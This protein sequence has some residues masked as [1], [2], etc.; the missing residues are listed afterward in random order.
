MKERLPEGAQQ[1]DDPGQRPQC[2][3]ADGASMRAQES[4]T[5]NHHLDKVRRST[6]RNV[7]L[8]PLALALPLLA[9]AALAGKPPLD[10]AKKSLSVAVAKARTKPIS[11]TGIC[12]GPIVIRNDG[13]RL[14]GVG[15]AIINGEGQD[16]VTIE[17]A[18][19]VSLE[20]MEVRD[21]DNGVVGINGAHFSLTDVDVLSNDLTGIS[22]QNASSAVLTRVTTSDNG[23]HGLDVETGSAATIRGDFASSGNGVFGVN[24]NGS[25]LTL[26]GATAT[27][28]GNTIGMQVATGANAF[29]SDSATLLNVDNNGAVGLTMVSGGHMVSFGGDISASGNGVNGVSLNS[30]A[31]LDLDAAST[32]ECN[33]NGTGLF[34]Q[35]ESEVTVFNTPQFSGEPGFSTVSCKNNT[36]KGILVRNASNLRLSG[37]AKVISTGN[38]GAGLTADDGAGV[39]LVSSE[40]KG[41]SINPTDPADPPKDIE[42]SFGT[43]ADIRSST[44]GTFSCDETVLL[45][46]EN[47]IICN[48]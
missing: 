4:A 44:I 17:G 34:V 46:G 42:L 21:G 29:I 11:F 20:N 37:Q 32:L 26:S 14:I 28:S 6:M 40:I 22:L 38:S 41:N 25:A 24:V 18:H 15:T 31:G 1:K 7:S 47:D 13:V 43:R 27:V 10:C 3:L 48:Q 8:L 23:L 9:D 36:D 33:E 45:R 35:Q 19:G 5:A 12:S 2:T 39:V 16:A 30:K